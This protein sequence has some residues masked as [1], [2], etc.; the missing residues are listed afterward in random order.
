MGSKSLTSAPREVLACPPRWCLLLISASLCFSITSYLKLPANRYTITVGREALTYLSAMLECCGAL[1]NIPTQVQHRVAMWAFKARGFRGPPGW[2]TMARL[3]CA[4]SWMGMRR[5][6]CAKT[7]TFFVHLHTFL[8]IS[9]VTCTAQ[10]L[11]R[12]VR[13]EG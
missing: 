6:S 9:V 13:L 7:S 5:K 1:P 3:Q 2:Q 12:H 8:Y 10:P 11:A 4:V